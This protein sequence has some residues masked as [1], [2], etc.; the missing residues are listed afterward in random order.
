M[1]KHIKLLNRRVISCS[2]VDIHSSQ[3]GNNESIAGR[4]G[5]LVTDIAQPT[6]LS[7]DKE[8]KRFTLIFQGNTF[9][10][11]KNSESEDQAQKKI[12]ELHAEMIISYAF[13]GDDKVKNVEEID[14]LIIKEEEFFKR[15][16]TIFTRDVFDSM[17][18][19]SSYEGVL[20]PY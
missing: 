8:E 5:S 7:F 12:F 3:K 4:N 19:K 14:D 13:I 15:D 2:F 10:T 17:L 6:T 20:L 18:R 1:S 16:A 11:V 9:A